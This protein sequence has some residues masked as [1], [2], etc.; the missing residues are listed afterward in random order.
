MLASSGRLRRASKFHLVVV[1]SGCSDGRRQEG[2]AC[3]QG[4]RASLYLSF[5]LSVFHYF[6]TSC[7]GKQE[8]DLDH[9]GIGIPLYCPS[10]FLS[11]SLFLCFIISLPRVSVYCLSFVSF[12]LFLYFIILLP[13]VSLYCISSVSLSLSFCISLFYYLVSISIVSLFL[14]FS[15]FLYFIILLLSCLSLLSLFLY[16]SLSPFLSLSLSSL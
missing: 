4:W 5:C 7:Q 8:Y 3:G 13:R 10:L 15:L 14:S 2:W 9:S 11:V 1:S 16:L 12:S 6:I